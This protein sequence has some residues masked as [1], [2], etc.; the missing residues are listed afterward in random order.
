MLTAGVDVGSLAAKAAILDSEVAVVVGGACVPTG[1][2]PAASGSR[3]LQEALA[4]ADV[5]GEEIAAVVATG[6]GREI[7]PGAHWRV[8]EIS[9]AARG[10]H[11]LDPQVRTV[12]DIGGQDSKAIRVDADGFPADFALNDRCAAGTGRF[13]EVMSEA[14]GVGVDELDDL[15]LEAERPAIITRTCTVFA[16]SEVVGLTARGVA[17]AE[18]AAGLCRA[19]AARVAQLAGT[20]GVEPRVMLIGGVALNRAIGRYLSEALSVELAVPDGPQF[21]VATGAAL[22]AAERQLAS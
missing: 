11:L 16:E 6:Y 17:P 13:L 7:L 18:I 21:V 22:I 3:A 8:T 5:S 10:A 9:C 15:A 1:S 20:L 4:E 2:D 12:I 19:T 14:L